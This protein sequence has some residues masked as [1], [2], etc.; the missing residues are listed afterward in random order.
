VWASDD[1][2]HAVYT[3]KQMAEY[4]D[5]AARFFSSVGIGQGDRVMLILKRRA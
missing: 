2:G 5:A 4:S 3:F 1:G